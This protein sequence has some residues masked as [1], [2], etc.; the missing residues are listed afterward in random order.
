M[1]D[2]VALN[3]LVIE[4]DADARANLRDLLEL[5]GHRVE[6]AASA[7]EALARS[8]WETLDLVILDR[9]LPDGRAEQ[10]LPRLHARAPAAAVI[11][12][13]GYSDLQGAI[14]ALREGASDY[15]LKPLHFDALR[16]SLLR[17]AE[18]RA[19]TRAKERSETALRQLLEAAECVILIARED[20]ELLYISPFGERLT[21]YELEAVRGRNCVELLGAAGSRQL[22]VEP[23]EATA[24]GRPVQGFE[25]PIV[26]RDGSVRTMLWNARRL[27]DHEGAPALMMVGQDITGLKLAQER[28][29]QAE[30]LAAIGQMV[31]GLAHE[32]RN[33]LQRSQACLE[34]LALKV[35][36]CPGAL[37]LIAR[38]QAA[39]DHLNHLFEDVRGYAA[40]V[41]LIRSTIRVDESWREAW[42]QLE[43]MRRTRPGRL[44]ERVEGV[45]LVCR[46]D[47]FRLAQ[48]FRNLFENAL[49]AGRPPVTVVVEAS[50]AVLDGQA[51]VQVVV[52]DDGPGFDRAIRERLFEPFFTTKTKGTGLGLPIARRI[53]EAHGGTMEVADRESPGA[54]FVITLPREAP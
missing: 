11:I 40:P 8:D 7:A 34:M 29:V 54:A 13:T 27:P 25:C 23:F 52:S 1:T 9:Q 30:R 26:C 12:V 33:A 44:I 39:Q 16:A 31:T 21:G 35:R 46:A 2:R 49:A 17:V 28:A 45:D 19:L 3:V 4:D 6:L 43:A 53:V 41:R 48:V 50:E 14:A 37:D 47:A 38:L 20:G 5:E 24:R 18:R 42:A 10:L 36:D 15:I 22:L 51:A 32:S